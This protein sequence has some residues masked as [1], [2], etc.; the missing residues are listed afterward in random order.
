MIEKLA[1][2]AT[3]RP[4]LAREYQSKIAHQNE[5]ARLGNSSEMDQNFPLKIVRRQSCRFVATAVRV[6]AAEF[7]RLN[8]SAAGML[9][10]LFKCHP[11]RYTP[12]QLNREFPALSRELPRRAGKL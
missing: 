6:A 12:A 11:Y 5:I 2:S 10:K 7:E 4:L 9:S 3:A 8:E 1:L